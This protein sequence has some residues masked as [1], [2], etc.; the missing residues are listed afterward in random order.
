VG[1]ALGQLGRAAG[2]RIA[3]VS[4]TE[5]A[6]AEQMGK[7]V[8]ANPL[9]A[10]DACIAGELILLTVSD[11]NIA[12]LCKKLTECGAFENKPIVAHCSGALGSDVLAAAAEVGSPTGSMHPLQTFP[13]TQTAMR[14]IPGTYFFIE[15]SELAT[16]PLRELATAIGGK[17]AIIN[18]DAKVCYHAAA[19]MASNYFVTLMDAGS[20]LLAKAGLT[21]T[22]SLDALEPL[23]RA[24]LENIFSKN[25]ENAGHIEHA[26]TGPIARGDV[27]TI[28][29]HLQA[30]TEVSP[31]TRQLYHTAGLR[32]I[33]LAEKKGTINSTQAEKLRALLSK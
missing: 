9:D 2:Y 25:A 22:E 31:E 10:S 19:V 8:D 15:G 3:A 1:S 16:G 11:D 7:L 17:P 32:T 26:L 6:R 12:P 18:S 24:T 33:S 13:D 30:L 28:Q 4:D 21:S 14:S 5:S 29:R 27:D 23:V 20:E